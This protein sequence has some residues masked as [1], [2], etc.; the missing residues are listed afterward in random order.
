MAYEHSEDVRKDLYQNIL[1]AIWKAL[2]SFQGLSQLSTYIYR[3][4]HNIGVSHS[5][6]AKR[7]LNKMIASEKEDLLFQDFQPNPEELI[8]KKEEALLLKEAVS[9]LSP[10]IKQVIVMHLEG[11]Q[12]KQIAEILGIK[13]NTVTVRIKR[14]K[15]ILKKKLL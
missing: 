14:G 12:N 7:G 3:I 11:M 1:I 6:K 2:P 9:D 13:E 5:I 10:A 8:L 4:A 15:E